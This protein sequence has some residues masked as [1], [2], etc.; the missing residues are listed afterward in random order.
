MSIGSPQVGRG[1]TVK[2]PNSIATQF[3]AA[4]KQSRQ[5]GQGPSGS[6]PSC[7]QLDCENCCHR[8]LVSP[9][10]KKMTYPLDRALFNEDFSLSDSSVRLLSRGAIAKSAGT[11][12]DESGA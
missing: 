8:P 7:E 10:P 12:R 4:Q 9:I 6:P 2:L 5:A 11:K 1:D 3:V